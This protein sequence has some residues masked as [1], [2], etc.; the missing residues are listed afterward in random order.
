M[1][2]ELQRIVD[3]VGARLRR[4]AALDDKVF[5]L[6][7]YSPH[8]GPVD[9]IRLA[10]I[11]HRKADGPVVD[12][13]RQQG[14]AKAEGPVRIPANPELDLLPRVCVPVRCRGVLLGYLWLVDA[15]EQLTDADLTV[16]AEAADAAGVVLY[17]EQL[18]EDLERARE[19]ELLRDLFASDIGTRQ[20]AAQELVDANLFVPGRE[21]VVL[22]LQPMSGEGQE[23]DETLQAAV[24]MALMQ[25]RRSLMMRNALHLGHHDRGVLLVASPQQRTGDGGWLADVGNQLKA[26]F[27]DSLPADA[28]PWRPIVGIGDPVPTL[29]EAVDS[30]RHAY[31]AARIAQI[32]E[33]GDVAVWSD[34]GVYRILAQLPA[35]E[36]TE[37][38]LHP[39]L[40]TLLSNEGGTPLLESLEC[41][42]DLVGDARAAAERLNVHRTTLYYRLNRIEQVAGVDLHKGSDRLALHLGLKIARL[43]GLYPATG[44]ASRSSSADATVNASPS[45]TRSATSHNGAAG[46]ELTATTT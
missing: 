24:D 23:P 35:E 34:L 44:A 21:T 6:Q 12:W 19:R 26:A 13:V 17:R 32:L 39:A 4:S 8:H 41:Y 28:G 46:S 14:I 45:T 1:T 43:A 30:Q 18:L 31:Q 38:A 42:L 37:S 40:V 7:V 29:A 27:I 11:L 36:L 25:L 2:S 15:E 9:E 33:M 22:A 3:T 20:H 10:S 16:A 5:R